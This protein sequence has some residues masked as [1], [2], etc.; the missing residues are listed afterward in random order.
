VATA[1]VTRV[2]VTSQD[3]LSVEMCISSWK[4]G[5]S[6]I[7][8]VCCSETVVPARQ[9]TAT[10]LQ[11]GICFGSVRSAIDVLCFVQRESRLLDNKTQQSGLRCG[12]GQLSRNS[13]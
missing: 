1:E 9:S 8:M 2:A 13:A 7:T 10:T 12:A 3:T 5:S 11:M 6:G 4:P